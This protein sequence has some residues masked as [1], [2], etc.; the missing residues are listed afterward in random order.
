M[1][2]APMSPPS[3]HR[4]KPER[5]ARIMSMKSPCAAAGHGKTENVGPQAGIF[6]RLVIEVVLHWRFGRYRSVRRQRQ[7]LRLADGG[8]YFPRIAADIEECR[9]DGSADG[10]ELPV[11]AVEI[12]ADLG[13]WI[14]KAA[15]MG[16]RAAERHAE[17][18][19][20]LRVDPFREWPYRVGHITRQDAIN[21]RNRIVAPSQRSRR[22]IEFRQLRRSSRERRIS[23]RDILRDKKSQIIRIAA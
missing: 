9:S 6:Q 15:G 16:H 1:R 5:V 22:R 17:I 7:F 10:R 20:A 18:T 19:D 23:F 12:D 4:R 8:R 21:Q 2:D 11:D 3:S 14:G 13:P